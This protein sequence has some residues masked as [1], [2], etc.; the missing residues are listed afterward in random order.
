[1]TD[2]DVIVVG[3][4]CGG[5][6]AGALL[7][8]EGRRVLVVE[9]GSRVGGCCSTFEADG[10]RFDVGASIVEI[11]EPIRWTFE[12][13]GTRLEDEVE[14]IPC[15]PIVSVILRD[16]SRVTYPLSMEGT[17]DA[18]ARI[19][20]ADAAN[21]DRYESFFH[22]LTD[23]AYST[24]FSEPANGLA[25]LARW[26]VKEPRLLRFLPAYLRSYEGFLGDYF[27]PKARET[28]AFQSFYFGL[29]P[30]LLPGLF[31][32]VPATEH[33]GLYYPRG[34][35][36]RI[37]EALQRIGERHGLTVRLETPVD[38]ILVRDGRVEGVQLADGTELTAHVVVSNVNAKRTYE[39][40]V[41]EEHLSPL[42]RRGVASYEYSMACMM[43]YL[44]M[45]ERP[46][47]EGHHTLI[48]PTIDEINTYFRG[49]R[50]HPVPEHH[51]GLIGWS[52]FADPGMAPEGKHALNLTM[53]GYS[54][55]GIDWDA[56]KQRVIDDVVDFLSGGIIPG[57]RDHV[58][59]A[60]ATTPL[61]FD[62]HVG[63]A[64]GA[65][66]GIEQS[67]PQQTIF[68]PA[69]RSKSVRGL[70]LAGSSTNPGGGVPTTI[71]SGA[72]TAGLVGRYEQ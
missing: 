31:T 7:A 26:I 67:L 36:I 68:R 9:Q 51:F 18:L 62:R 20:P 45:D 28:F 70:Y 17:K 24:L 48:A 52:T 60:L 32:L 43:I 42:V 56:E 29:P 40:L 10:Y 15:D 55:D 19:S 65:I 38:R 14:M 2:Y 41:G 6:S 57:L 4:G 30:E 54:F 64:H 34:G 16:G 69:N 37:P 33:R 35:M 21:W 59:V 63:I 47:L 66:Y 39:T 23:V 8:K 27:S 44:G 61:D 11:V 53:G 72:I 22:E 25:D 13:L 46:P 50:S 1:M 58:E 12:R 71:A 49:R 5:L 3:A